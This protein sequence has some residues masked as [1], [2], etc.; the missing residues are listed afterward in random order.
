MQSA[1][2]RKPEDFR[3]LGYARDPRH[4]FGRLQR[5]ATWNAAGPALARVG[6][7][8]IEGTLDLTLPKIVE[9]RRASD[10]SHR[11]LMKL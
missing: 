2:D 8:L 4:L 9:E 7:E 6:R 3:E 1:W 11:V 5:V 10:V